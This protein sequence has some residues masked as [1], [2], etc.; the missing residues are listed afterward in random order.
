[1]VD[2]FINAAYQEAY[3]DSQ[4]ERQ[5][6]DAKALQVRSLAPLTQSSSTQ[7]SSNQSS[8]TQS[9]SCALP[10]SQ[11]QVRFT[12]LT[13]GVNR[14]PSVRQATPLEPSGRDTQATQATQ[15]TQKARRCV[16]L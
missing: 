16:I 14:I 1:M 2:R 15:A 6:A 8:S 13:P 5:R 10:S 4:M 3:W 9:S 11:A 7:S 12:T